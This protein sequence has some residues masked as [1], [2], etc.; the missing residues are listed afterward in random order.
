MF[1]NAMLYNPPGNPFHKLAARIKKASAPVYSSLIEEVRTLGAFSTTDTPQ[2]MYLVASEASLRALREPGRK[3][4]TTLLDELFAYEFEP[5]RPPTPPPKPKR[6]IDRAEY[7]AKKEARAA[8]YDGPRIPGRSTRHTVAL[9]IDQLLS[10]G[11][12]AAVLGDGSSQVTPRG[13][14]SRTQELRGNASSD[15]AEREPTEGRKPTR[16]RGRSRLHSES[17][18]LSASVSN[19]SAGTGSSSVVPL[20]RPQRGVAG[21]ETYSPLGPKER[22]ARD[23]R[24]A[25]ELVVDNLDSRDDFKRFN[26]GWVLPEGTKRGGRRDRLLDSLTDVVPS[27]TRSK[28]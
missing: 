10:A 22:R 14:R 4:N 2:D 23:K 6:K 25:M 27:R 11:T 17:T 18:N 15:I 16:G 9:G 8:K 21:K 26:V 13:K 7:L 12:P 3:E 20:T 19:E 5:P 24:M 28:S 1:D